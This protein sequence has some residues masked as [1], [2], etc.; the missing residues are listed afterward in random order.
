MCAG[1]GWKGARSRLA[2]RYPKMKLSLLPC[3]GLGDEASSSEEYSV[4]SDSEL[5]PERTS[6]SWTSHTS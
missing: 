2:E 6:S 5:T 1:L 4:S 3:S